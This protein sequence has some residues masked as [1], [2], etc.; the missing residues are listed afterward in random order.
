MRVQHKWSK[1]EQLKL[2]PTNIPRIT[3]RKRA[4][5]LR[6]VL[7][8]VGV[9]KRGR[10]LGE[11]GYRERRGCALLLGV[12]RWREEREGLGDER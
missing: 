9:D 7:C 11:E 1:A 3:H 8:T 5:L 4:G 10:L 12:R 6:E 2:R